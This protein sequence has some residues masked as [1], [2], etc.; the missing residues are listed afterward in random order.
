M[1]RLRLP[2]YHKKHTPCS[3]IMIKTAYDSLIGYLKIFKEDWKKNFFK[4]RE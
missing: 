1:N 3:F 4:D 2:I